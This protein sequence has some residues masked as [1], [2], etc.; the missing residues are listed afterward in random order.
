MPKDRKDPSLTSR[1]R[2]ARLDRRRFLQAGAVGAAG[3]GL[4][5]RAGRLIDTALTRSSNGSSLSDIE[6]VVILM[7]ENRSFDHYFGTLSGVRGFSDKKVLT[8]TV[9]GQTYPIFDQFG[10]E[11]GAGVTTSGYLQPFSLKSDPPNENGQTT[12]DITHDWGPQH[13]SWDNGAMDA[14]VQQHLLNDG[15]QNGLL[16]MGYFTR[17]NLA[18]YYALADAFTICDAYHC[19]VLGPTDPNR[20]MSMSATIDPAGVAGGPCLVT[21]TG[22]RQALYGTFTWTTMPEQL[23]AA[24]VSW[25]VYND[26]TALLELS[27]FPY[28]Q[29]FWEPSSPAQVEMSTQALGYNYPANFMA[30]VT[31]GTLPQVSWIMPNLAECEHPAAPPEYGEHLVQEILDILVSNPDVWASTVF[32]INYDENGGFF[33]H[34]PPPTPLGGTDGEYLTVDPLPSDASGIAGPVGLGFRVPCLVVSPFS[35]G[36]YVCSHTFDHTSTLRFLETL[37]GVEVPNLSAWRRSVTGDMTEALA[38]VNP[39]NTTV[40]TLPAT[41][42]GDT[43]VAEQAV[44]NALA[45]TEDVG[46]PYPAP[47]VN[48]MPS[49]ATTPPRP[50]VP[51][52]L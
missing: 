43:S 21:Q 18:F 20:V 41:S 27:P 28:F 4:S 23:S 35:A 34:V 7:Q 9:N 24:G 50:R 6:H 2:D 48:R 32:I 26:P 38:L 47:T 1:L 25:K 22:E 10:Y 37:F 5:S 14:F 13:L 19:S 29:P 42:L 40:P 46:I 52:K 49:Q 17:K 12:N 51:H 31:A 8:Q 15:D 44:I 30:D 33:D 39:P 3:V 36:G 16:T 45:G 11:P